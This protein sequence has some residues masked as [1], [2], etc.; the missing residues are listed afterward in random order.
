MR[1][2]SVLR[3]LCHIA[4]PIPPET[5]EAMANDNWGLPGSPINTD[6]TTI[7]MP[8]QSSFRHW[9]E[10]YCFPTVRRA[11]HIAWSSPENGITLR[12]KAGTTRSIS[13]KPANQRPNDVTER[14]GDQREKRRAS[15]KPALPL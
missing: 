9:Y 10:S 4:E 5:T 7:P 2:L 3:R 6:S 13:R 8:I 12:K 14:S 15:K 1:H 11:D